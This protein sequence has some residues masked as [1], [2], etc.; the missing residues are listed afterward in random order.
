MASVAGGQLSSLYFASRQEL[1]AKL[2]QAGRISITLEHPTCCP[3]EFQSAHI[4]CSS[5]LP[6]Y[7]SIA[8]KKKKGEKLLG[9]EV[10]PQEGGLGVVILNLQA[11]YYF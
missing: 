7:L 2:H 8:L 1:L 3:Q 10:V 11:L 4:A 5:D 6:R 9:V